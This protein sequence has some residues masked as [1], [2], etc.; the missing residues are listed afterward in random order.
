MINFFRHGSKILLTLILCIIIAV[1][2]SARLLT[3][4]A[5]LRY[6]RDVYRMVYNGNLGL[7]EALHAKLGVQSDS[8][9]KLLEG[10][11]HDSNSSYIVVS[12]A[13]HTLWYKQGNQVLF[14]APV[15][16][17][18][19]K[20]LVGKSDGEHWR[21]ETPR[22]RLVVQSKDENPFWI[23]PEWYYIEQAHKRGLGLAHIDRG[24]PVVAKDGSKYMVEGS[25]VVRQYPDGHL[26]PLP[27]PKEG[28]ELTVNGNI[29]VPPFGT[30]QRRYLGTL[31]TRRLDLGD[32]YGIHGTDDPASI[33]HS[34]S[35]GCVRMHNEDVEQ[36]YPMVPV[37]TPVYIY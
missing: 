22:G 37:G 12:I 1:V 7:L 19:G 30:T 34:V 2:A 17:A 5:E 16:T 35:H 20:E 13:D 8:M 3:D 36:L 26:E 18:S 23:P 21:F 10:P 32:G 31:G 25:D 28:H 14:T 9:R 4:T 15:A 11:K 27:A 24:Q 29:L 6:D 33:G